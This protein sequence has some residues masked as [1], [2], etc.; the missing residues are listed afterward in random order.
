[1]PRIRTGECTPPSPYAVM[2]Y[3]ETILI[4]LLECTQKSFAEIPFI[5][6]W[7]L[8]FAVLILPPA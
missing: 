6:P 7:N 5:K 3:I 4:H 1:V 2:E 8:T